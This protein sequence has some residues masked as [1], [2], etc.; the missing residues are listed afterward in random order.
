MISS[1]KEALALPRACWTSC[2]PVGIADYRKLM[3]QR[4]ASEHQIMLVDLASEEM[5]RIV[6][7][8]WTSRSSTSCIGASNL[9]GQFWKRLR[10]SLHLNLRLPR[11]SSMFRASDTL[12]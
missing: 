2:T 8:F 4:R 11:N 10:S 5:Q 6:D 12:N 9:K 3:R 1:L 7:T